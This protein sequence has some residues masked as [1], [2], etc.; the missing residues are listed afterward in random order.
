MLKRNE[1]DDVDPKT[2]EIIKFDNEEELMKAMKARKLVALKGM[3]KKSC[4]KCHGRG[5]VGFDIVKREYIVCSC[6]RKK[7]E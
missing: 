5:Y 7:K 4:K 2:G 3:P 1:E 6:V